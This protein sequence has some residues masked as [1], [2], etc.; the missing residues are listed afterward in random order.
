[1]LQ[2]QQSA[3][4]DV[5]GRSG[6]RQNVFSEDVYLFKTGFETR[7]EPNEDIKLNLLSL[8]ENR[9]KTTLAFKTCYEFKKQMQTD[10]LDIISNRVFYV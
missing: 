7:V 5:P 1:M 4:G 9:F 8:I 6:C 3:S 10:N 2:H